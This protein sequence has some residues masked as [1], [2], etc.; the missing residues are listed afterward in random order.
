MVAGAGQDMNELTPLNK[1]GV[2]AGR[3]GKA[4][5]LKSP[6]FQPSDPNRKPGASKATGEDKENT[7]T[8]FGASSNMVNAIIGAG[9]VGIPFAIKEAGLVAG[10]FLVFL[11]AILTEKSLRVL[12]ETA[13]L[14]KVPSY[15]T[16]MEVAFG[17]TGFLFVLINM[18]ILSYGAMVSYLMVI[19][20]TL[21][22]I[23]G[24]GDDLDDQPLRQGILFVS[25]LIVI[26]PLSMQ[27]DVADL[28][29][30]SKINC[31]LDVLMVLLLV[32]LS[33]EENLANHE[34][35]DSSEPFLDQVV[36]LFQT[37]V[38]HGSTVFVG[39]GVLSFAFVCQHSA[40]IVA[41]SLETPTRERWAKVTKITVIIC[42]CLAT[43]MGVSGYLAYGENTEGNIL[44]N[45][46]DSAASNVTRAF[47]ATTMFFVYPLESFVARHVM[48]V[49]LFQGKIAHDGDDHAVLA[50]P[51][52]RR[53]LTLYLY[54]A[55]IVPAILFRDLGKVLSLT[56][57]IG[58]SSLSY[59]GPG[60]VY[61]G[62]HGKKFNA[63]VSNWWVAKLAG[64]DEQ[65]DLDTEGE[66]DA[67]DEAVNIFS[68]YVDFAKRMLA[69]LIY[70]IFLF[71]I[72]CRIAKIGA[73]LRQAHEYKVT[74]AT[75]TT[76]GRR[77][78]GRISSPM[79][80]KPMLMAKSG[81]LADEENFMELQ[82]SLS[83]AEC[84]GDRLAPNSLLS[85]STGVSPGTALKSTN[86]N[87]GKLYLQQSQAGTKEP[88]QTDNAM[89][90][91]FV[92]AIGIILFG[93]VAIVAGLFSLAQQ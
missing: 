70:Y 49:L 31:A 58:G 25:S 38:I 67:T 80:Q 29:K 24:V 23:L 5:P 86:Q 18:F 28:A 1:G 2:A 39:L 12:I 16:V 75:P 88:D 62:I 47:L 37:D 35:I 74:L 19:K 79:P 40:F 48:V 15:E 81:E 9:I 92:F 51:D 7:S 89:I 27:R 64:H 32:Y 90:L 61:L 85:A 8:I 33:P 82:R 83:M 73:E 77:L 6:F 41:G 56:G 60:M 84:A 52:R 91:D 14:M 59:I 34:E 68:K 53:N 87:L 57:T 69:Y 76:R 72:W 10:I 44:N 50:R 65:S 54:T 63:L 30:T 21:P 17:K 45:L 20:D 3:L 11:C 66:E 42:G 43:L 36:T 26:V 4:M 22:S 71:P 13:K 46:D 78:R 93:V 55:A